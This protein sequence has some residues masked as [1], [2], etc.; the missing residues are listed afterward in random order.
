MVVH[1]LF[2]NFYILYLL[3]VGFGCC[4][5][6][7]KAMAFRSAHNVNE[8]DLSVASPPFEVKLYS[9]MSTSHRQRVIRVV[10]ADWSVLC[11][12]R[13]Q[14]AAVSPPWS[15][16]GNDEWGSIVVDTR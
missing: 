4:W 9:F 5:I 7:C 16:Q 14:S 8:K 3:L 13:L 2:V 11:I 10:G 6:E 12:H 1:L 15:H